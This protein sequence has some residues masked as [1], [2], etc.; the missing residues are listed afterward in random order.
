MNNFKI[1]RK[2]KEVIKIKQMNYESVTIKNIENV[3]KTG[4][5]TGFECDGDNKVLIVSEVECKRIEEAFN[6]LQKSVENVVSTI[7]ETFKNMYN[8][9]NSIFEIFSNKLNGKITKK[10]FIKLLQSEGIQRNTINKIIKNN[11]EEYTYSRYLDT[12]KKLEGRSTYDR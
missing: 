6:E 7:S 10:R 1:F 3:I 5:I 4:Y 2:S 8:T 9:F 11:K 12:L